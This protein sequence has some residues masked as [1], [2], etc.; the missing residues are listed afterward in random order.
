MNRS[1]IDFKILELLNDEE[2]NIVCK[3]VD[4]TL[5]LIPIKDKRYEKY[6]KKLG[7]LDKKNALVQKVLPGI[8]FNLC[9]KIDTK[10]R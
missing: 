7:R 4:L 10:C 3:N 6:T 8:A 1:D 5:F 2:I 9:K